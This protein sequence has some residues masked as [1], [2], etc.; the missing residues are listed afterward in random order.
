MEEQSIKKDPER[1]EKDLSK[2]EKDP[3]KIRNL[4]VTKISQKVSE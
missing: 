4:P 1:A 2:V 3:D